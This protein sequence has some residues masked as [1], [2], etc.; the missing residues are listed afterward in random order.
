MF[1]PLIDRNPNKPTIWY[2]LYH[3]LMMLLIS[4]DLLL[5]TIDALM[6]ST[7]LQHVAESLGFQQGV[8]YYQQHYHE[9][10]KVVGG[11]FTIFLVAELLLRWGIAIV[12]KRYYRWFFYPFIH[13]YEVL[14]CLPQLRALRLLRAVVIGYRLHQMG[15]HF[16]PKSWYKTIHFYYSMIMEEIS[17]RVILMA[18]DNIRTEIGHANGHLVHNIINKHR[19]DMERLIVELLQQEVTPL[20][21]SSSPN[22]L[23]DF[24]EPLAKKV[25]QS[26][27]Q[28]LIETPELRRI[29]RLIPIA[30]AMI[31]EQMMNIGQQ[32]GEN[33]TKS[34]SKNLTKAET[35]DQV[36][37]HIAQTLSQVDTTSPT[38][39]KLVISIMEESLT[40]LAEQVKIQQWKQKV[41]Q[42]A[43]TS[44]NM[45]G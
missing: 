39:E 45:V 24:A 30:G 29:M 22:T 27:Q 31:E 9:P 25:G 20:L 15:W 40:A 12:Q 26:I 17:D 11:F 19:D 41:P 38:L 23:P 43:V 32:I 3:A 44:K 1:A 21:Q 16:L 13:W 18:I 8:I 35:L 4:I 7:F 42:P 5:I 2:L 28:S 33:L 37:R 10:I 14:G 36:Y 34:L 6:M